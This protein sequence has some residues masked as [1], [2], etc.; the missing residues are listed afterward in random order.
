MYV[1]ELLVVVLVYFFVINKS[2]NIQNLLVLIPLLQK[3]VDLLNVCTLG[4]KKKLK[5]TNFIHL[6]IYLPKKT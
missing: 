6:K 1:R 3:N 5:P 2:L 4:H